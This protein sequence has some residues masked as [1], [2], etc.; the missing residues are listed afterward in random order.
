LTIDELPPVRAKLYLDVLIDLQ[1]EYPELY[2]TI[3]TAAEV[4]EANEENT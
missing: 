4:D 3:L 2:S 1:K